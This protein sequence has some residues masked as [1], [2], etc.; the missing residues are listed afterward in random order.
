MV[1]EVNKNLLIKF[2]DCEYGW[3]TMWLTVDSY[4]LTVGLSHIYDP[5]PDM[6]AWLEAIIIGVEECGFNIDEEGSIVKFF[7]RKEFN[8]ILEPHLFT[9]L[10][11]M[12]NYDVQ[13]LQVTLP[14]RELVKI[15][16]HAFRDFATS[17]SYVR[18]HWEHITLKQVLHEQTGMTVEAWIDSVVLLDS[19]QVQKALWRLDRDITANEE[20]HSED[21]GNEADLLELTGQ[22]KAEVGG[23][24]LY[25]P[26]PHN[27]W[28]LHAK[29]D[30]PA[31][32]AFLCECL[33][34]TVTSSWDGC[35]WQKMRSL[36]IE[37][38]LDTDRLD[39][40]SF[41]EKWLIEKP[42]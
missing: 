23:L 9:A 16:Y 38:W 42:K 33:S 25:W 1:D 40:R 34:D 26:L 31:Q 21:V 20:D 17:D 4:T 3:I 27:L 10:N 14:T 15:F 22:T 39:S 37:E 13:P 11:V 30:E 41:W 32:R 29:K 5:L 19:R 35:P 2:G 28:G 12:P 8:S 36:M 18:E 6:L 7:A 24:P